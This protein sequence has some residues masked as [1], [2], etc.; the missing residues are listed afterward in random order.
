MSLPFLTMA[1]DKVK[2]LKMESP[3]SGGTETDEF[4]T[5]VND[6][7]DYLDAKGI[8]FSSDDN[9][10]IDIAADGSLQFSDANFTNKKFK[11]LVSAGIT[12][13][14]GGSAASVYLNAQVFDGGTA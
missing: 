1:K 2:P 11:D 10:C 4:P 5:E 7:E 13:L 6:S 9:K 3:A 12:N 14:D 8:V